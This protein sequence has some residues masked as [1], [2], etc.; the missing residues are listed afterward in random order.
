MTEREKER[1]NACE[2]ERYIK[3]ALYRV[4]LLDHAC[5]CEPIV[6]VYTL[7]AFG[8]IDVVKHIRL[9]GNLDTAE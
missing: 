2:R 6:R 3:R 1:E 5:I 7:I 4:R 9:I 8:C